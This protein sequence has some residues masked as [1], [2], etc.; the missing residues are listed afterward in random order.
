M[1]IINR[2][3]SFRLTLI[4]VISLWSL[5]AQAAYL[6]G[7]INVLVEDHFNT[8]QST[9]IYTIKTNQGTYTLQ[10]A[11]EKMK[12]HIKTGDIVS[13]EGDFIQQSSP[14]PLFHVKQIKIIKSFK[15]SKEQIAGD[16]HTL[17]M[18]VD[19]NDKKTTDTTS[20]AQVTGH[21]Y[22]DEKSMRQNFLESSFSQTNFVP[23]TNEDGT[24]DV[25]TVQLNYNAGNACKYNQW[26][27]DA[28]AA[29]AAQGIDTSLYRHFMFVLP[30]NANCG[31]GGLAHLG[32]G[33]SC[34]TWIK[35][36]AKIVYAHELG[37]NL[38]MH[39]ASTDPNNDGAVNS[40]YGDHSGIMGNGGYRQVNAPHR[41]QMN[42]YA[43]YSNNIKVFSNSGRVKLFSLDKLPEGSKKQIAIVNKEGMNH[44]YYLSYRTDIGIFGMGDKYARKINIH[45]FPGPGNRTL[46][47]QALS[48]GE[49]FIDPY[50][51]I[52]ITANKLG[53]NAGRAK[54]QYRPKCS[55]PIMPCHIESNS[56]VIGLDGKK[57][58]LKLDVPE[59]ASMLT[60]D[61]SETVESPDVNLFVRFNEMPTNQEYDCRSNSAGGTQICAIENPQA[62][63]W[64]IRI[65]SRDP[66]TGIIVMNQI[67]NSE[68]K[69]Q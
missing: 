59:G 67:D 42:W 4:A 43:A 52:K 53:D 51:G 40:E 58:Y 9:T 20:V 23:D 17:V 69:K 16:H 50:Q 61:T 68:L 62:G 49:S 64:Y 7:E 44:G 21:M 6:N 14:Q 65:N 3:K 22:T 45:R 48:K 55:F 1:H 28:K 63:T 38:G 32:C 54:V 34:H 60:V 30:N 37:H 11:K 8:K 57:N 18:L 12:Q 29:A 5:Q 15:P 27:N 41:I 10:L 66:H 35:W 31:W 39:H 47:L 24:P 56:E 13:I 2:L 46:F 19:F 33:S 26:A 36:N 25:Y